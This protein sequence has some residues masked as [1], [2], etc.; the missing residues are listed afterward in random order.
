VT[1]NPVSFAQG[2]PQLR[3]EILHP[4]GDFNAVMNVWVFD[5]LGS[6]VGHASLEKTPLVR[7][8]GAGKNSVGLSRILPGEIAP[9]L[10]I[11]RTRLRL[12]GE[13]GT[14]DAKFKFAVDR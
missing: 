7:D 5:I 1:P 4:E 3:F 6:V 9:G 12:L 2:E 8:F 13:S 11:C 14:F 10:Y